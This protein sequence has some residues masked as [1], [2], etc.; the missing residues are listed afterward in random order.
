MRPR[1]LPSSSGRALPSPTRLTASE[2]PTRRNTTS[3]PASR[4]R[5]PG[6]STAPPPS[7]STPSWVARASATAARSSDRKAASPSSTKISEIVRPVVASTSWSV[8]RAATPRWSAN[9]PATVVLPAPIGPISTIIG[10]LP[11]AQGVEVGLGVAAGLLPRVTAELLQHRVGEHQRHHRLRDDA[12]GR[13]RADV[14]A[15][16]VCHRRLAGRDVDGAQGPRHGRDRLHRGPH[17]Q[18][19][20]GGHAALG[21]AGPAA[22]ATDAL[23]RRH[24]LVV[25]LR[26][27]GGGELEAVAD[28]DA[29]DRL[30]AH[31]RAG[32]ARVEAAVPVHVRPEARR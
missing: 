24:D 9:R 31:E 8:S 25:G 1:T 28:L 13:Y 22:R 15:L 2:R 12:G 5:V 10:G 14:G 19:L 11:E 30:D 17:A 7:A 3:W 18:H 23:G 6:S 4:S 29:L 26:T 20:T 27:G 16:V 21:A 32:E